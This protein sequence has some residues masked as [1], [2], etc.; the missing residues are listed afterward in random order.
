MKELWAVMFPR[1]VPLSPTLQVD[2]PK[3]ELAG[4]W[5]N[6]LKGTGGLAPPHPHL[7]TPRQHCCCLLTAVCWEDPQNPTQQTHNKK[8]QV[9]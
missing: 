5:A 4:V 9:K 8:L 1:Q 7:G 3:G 6:D 2:S